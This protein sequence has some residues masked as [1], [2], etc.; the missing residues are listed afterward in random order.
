MLRAARHLAGLLA[1]LL[2][3][4]AA[5]AL[6]P[7]SGYL[8]CRDRGKLAEAAPVE[9]A[10]PEPAPGQAEVARDLAEFEA[11]LKRFETENKSFRD[12]VQVLVLRQVEQR[13]RFVADQFEQVI[14]DLDGLERLERDQ[15]I[16]RFEAFLERNPDDPKFTP[17]VMF[18]LAELYY[19]R[20]ND[21]F[22]LASDRFHVEARRAVAE[23]REPPPEPVKSY[24]PS[25]A[26]YQRLL[27]GFPDYQFTHGITYLLAWCLGEMGQGEEA[28]A[29]YQ[30]LIERFPT[31]PFVPEAWIR[32]GDWHFDDVAANSL[33]QAAEAFSR[34]YAYPDHPLYSRAVYKLGWTY[35]RLDDFPKAVDA[36]TRLLDFYVDRA[37]RAGEKPGGDVW[38]EAIQYT[39]ISLADRSWGGVAK[40]KAFFAERG[41]RPYEAEVFG[42]LGDILAEQTR[43]ADAVEAWQ[44]VLERDPLSPEAPATQ[45][46]IIM[47]WSRDRR[48]DRE[49][50]ARQALV[51]AYSEGTPWFQKHKGDPV[52]ISSVRDLIEK[53][54]LRAAS[55]HHAQ[56]QALKAA[57]KTDEA[58]AQY[59][60]AAKAYGEELARA[61]HSK[62]AHELAYS[63]ADCLYNSQDYEK[64]ARAYE[65]VR[66]DPADDKY[67]SESAVSAVLSWEGEVVRLQRAGELPELKVLLSTDC[68][69]QEVARPVPLPVAYQGLVRDTDVYVSRRGDT[70]QAATLAFKAGEAFYEHNDFDEAR[71]RFEEVVARWPGDEVAQFAANLIIESYLAVKDWQA[72]E[73]ASARLQ[74]TQVAS[75]PKLQAT[76]QKFKLGGRFNRA[77]Q[78]M[79]QKQYE[80]AAEL[81]IKLVQEDPRHEFADKALYNAASCYEGARRFESALRMYERLSAEYPK[82]A[83]ASEAL[84]RV[85]FNAENTYDFEKAIERYLLLVEKYPKAKQRKEA[86]YNAARAQE[87]LQRYDAA[88]AGFVRYATTYPDAEDAART[89]FHAALIYQRS[90]EWRKQ[91]AALQDFNRRFGKSREHEL[92]VQSQLEMALAWR[93]LKDEKAARAGFTATVT[94]FARRNLKPETSPG[95]AAAAAEARF[96]LAEYEFERYDAITLPATTD[97]KKLQKALQAKFAEAKRVA[98]L[99]DEVGRYK[100]PDWILAAFYRKAYLLERLAQTIYDAPVPAEFKKPGQE[101]YL[102]AYQDG[103]AQFAQPY[104][105][106]AVAVYVQAIEAA[107]KL[108]VKN[109]WTKKIGESL[110]RYRPKEYPI[111]KEA[112]SR[113]VSEDLSAVPLAD[114]PDGPARAAPKPAPAAAPAET[115]P[116]TEAPAPAAAH[117]RRRQ[118]RGGREMN[119]TPLAGWR[120]PPSIAPRRRRAAGAAGRLRH[121]GRPCG[122]R[123]HRRSV[124]RLR[125]AGRSAS[126]RGGRAVPARLQPGPASARGRPVRPGRRGLRG[127]RGRRSGQPEGTA[128]DLQR[129]HR[130]GEGQPARPGGGA[131]SAADLALPRQP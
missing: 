90:G 117:R 69:D 51:D 17:D 19:E 71:C 55:F 33:L 14:E 21:D 41:G 129:R 88:A 52:L 112:R 36:F 29:A 102:A 131:A 101:E 130:L 13:R 70:A 47:A 66:D 111:L 100:R 15:A 109:E 38:P 26:L 35:Y 73:T 63:H 113:L 30:Q 27:T 48:F 127:L 120:L 2:L 116:A 118:A 98:P 43:F 3:P 121:H 22:H 75:N 99:Y 122:R 128:G 76:L 40:A 123:R 12:E 106:Q 11:S 92:L 39:A 87:N 64:A 97:P 62:Q 20:S 28:Q 23:G 86:L 72:V 68:K 50:E 65:A 49:V 107:R 124:R 16:S 18:R 37:Q 126:A 8:S 110:A 5:A 104:E 125:R 114:T 108:H 93:E 89:Q 77:M 45:S 74:S 103:L 44:V 79:D 46:K 85:G 25:I 105:E 53:S 91:I 10:A 67:W 4:A 95:A 7:A 83:L 60:L 84:F 32:L 9:S 61:P 58:V 119:R 54:L 80:P 1:L 115:P 82:S 42:R 78:L 81:F 59:R 34:I 31:S 6:A 96:R 24:A 56:A 94:E 57:G